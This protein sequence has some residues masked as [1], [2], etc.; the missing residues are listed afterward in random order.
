MATQLIQKQA[1]APGVQ[2]GNWWVESVAHRKGGYQ[3]WHC[4]CLICDQM[5]VRRQDGL[6]QG[7]SRGCQGCKS[8]FGNESHPVI[9][10][11]GAIR[12]RSLNEA[13]NQLRINRSSLKYAIAK[14]ISL[15]GHI[16]QVQQS[17]GNNA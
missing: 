12:Y 6:V 3:F 9:S 14:K 10:A 8:A 17:R 16:W 15:S 13:A 1:I 4:K 7:K 5:F 2:Y 11:D